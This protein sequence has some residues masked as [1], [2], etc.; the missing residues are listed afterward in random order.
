MNILLK[1]VKKSETLIYFL[2][3]MMLPSNIIKGYI[4]VIDSVV[5][6]TMATMVSRKL[7]S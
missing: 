4:R 7:L 6:R 5:I 2:D 1:I 3:N